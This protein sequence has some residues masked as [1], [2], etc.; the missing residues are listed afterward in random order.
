MYKNF[1]RSL[2]FLFINV[3]FRN[4]AGPLKLIVECKLICGEMWIDWKK[5]RG[6]PPKGRRILRGLATRIDYGN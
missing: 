5:F 6:G 3:I 4:I 2:T 1:H